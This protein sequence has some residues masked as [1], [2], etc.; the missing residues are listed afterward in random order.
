[1]GFAEAMISLQLLAEERIGT[2]M[3]AGARAIDEQQDAASAGL[4]RKFG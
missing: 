1:M 3:R 2:G 4:H